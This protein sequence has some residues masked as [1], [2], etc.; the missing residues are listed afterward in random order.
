MD[1]H[2]L[3]D[4]ADAPD[5]L[6]AWARE[7]DL[8]FEGAW[9]AC[10]RGDH[11][12]WL[13]ACGGAPIERVIEAAAAALFAVEASVAAT[14][15]MI[16]EALTLAISGGGAV[17]LLTAAEACERIADGG[18]ADYRREAGP[19]LEALARSSALIARAAE[20]LIAGD[21]RREAVRL[22][23]ARAAGAN[24]GIGMQSV[25]PRGEGP[26]RLDILAAAADPAQGSFLFCVAACA[27]ALLV[28]GAEGTEARA[29]DTIVEDTLRDQ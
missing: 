10:A 21:A 11:R 17:E 14:S 13:A 25:L 15:T 19:D 29:L 20:A 28:A 5:D 27:E 8:D 24:L 22:E 16:D 23:Q 26:A 4:A 2:E 18:M 7:E 12:L 6:V 9:V 1:L 3:L